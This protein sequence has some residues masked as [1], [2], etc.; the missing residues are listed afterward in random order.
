[1]L[2]VRIAA[3]LP[4]FP[5]SPPVGV[6]PCSSR[7]VDELSCQWAAEDGFAERPVHER[8]ESLRHDPQGLVAVVAYL[9]ARL[10]KYPRSLVGGSDGEG[11]AC[12]DGEGGGCGGSGGENA[13]TTMENGGDVCGAITAEE[14]TWVSSERR[15]PA[16]VKVRSVIP[17]SLVGRSF[18]GWSVGMVHYVRCKHMGRR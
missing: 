10:S 17:R 5:E 2:Y 12:N 15:C 16:R 13:G 11:G 7:G 18:C 14:E 8:W 4:A 6:E 1:M 9:E 3:G